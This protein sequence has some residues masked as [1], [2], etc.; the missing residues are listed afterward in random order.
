MI[1]ACHGIQVNVQPLSIGLAVGMLCSISDSYKGSVVK[2]NIGHAARLAVTVPENGAVIK[3]LDQGVSVAR[4]E[5][6]LL[7]KG[8]ADRRRL[9]TQQTPDRPEAALWLDQSLRGRCQTGVFRLA[10]RPE[11]GKGLKR[12]LSAP[13]L[14]NNECLV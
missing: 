6:C 5:T 8:P 13:L 11:A 9:C 1:I 4:S 7:A 3:I 12:S 2:K 14:K 10:L